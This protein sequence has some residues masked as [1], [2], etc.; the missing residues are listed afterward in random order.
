LIKKRGILK[1]KACSKCEKNVTRNNK[2]NLGVDLFKSHTGMFLEDKV[3]CRECVVKNTRN[4]LES[5]SLSGILSDED[6]IE[7]FTQDK[8]MQD[9][10]YVNLFRNE[11]MAAEMKF[12]EQQDKKD[13]NV[14]SSRK[15]KL[16]MVKDNETA[17]DF[18]TKDVELIPPESLIKSMNNVIIGQDSAKKSLALALFRHQL[19]IKCG[20]G[21]VSILIMGPTGT[22]KTEMVNTIARELD[23]PF[24]KVDTTS[25]TPSGYKGP[26]LMSV[27][28]RLL[29]AAGGDIDKAEKGIIMFDEVDKLSKGKETNVMLQHELLK[30]IEGG[31]YSLDDKDSSGETINT[32]NIMFILVG[33]F[34]G[35]DKI[36]D[37]GIEKRIGL[38]SNNINI[39]ELEKEASLSAY[40]KANQSHIVEYGLIPELVGRIA[41]VTNTNPLSSKDLKEILVESQLSPLKSLEKI[42][43]LYGKKVKF[44][45]KLLDSIC[46]DAVKKGLGARMLKN[47][48]NEKISEYIFSITTHKGKTIHIK[49]SD[50]DDESAA[51]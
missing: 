16:R 42:A 2:F 41:S 15:P 3:L 46:E 34:S 35:I 31:E 14:K 36:I 39:K 45:D 32:E 8:G 5:T 25:I 48:L 12:K 43:D 7:I 20:S 29:S 22:G 38:T 24:V 21:K 10:I 40:D 18:Q 49:D 17:K 47:A 26:G 30:F 1:K 50:D 23:A 27:T 51:A 4:A 44:C 13:R 11:I 6:F 19:H 33:A 28:Q 9:Q 37:K